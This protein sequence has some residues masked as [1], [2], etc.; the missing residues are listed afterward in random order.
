MNLTLKK[1]ALIASSMIFL[2]IVFGYLLIVYFLDPKIFIQDLPRQWWILP[3]A[4]I[5]AAIR[6][7]SSRIGTF[8]TRNKNNNQMR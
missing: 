7:I 8:T 5:V 1:R 2:Y 6:F 3:F 4:F